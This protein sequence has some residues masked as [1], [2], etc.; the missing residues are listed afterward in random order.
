[1]QSPRTG[2]YDLKETGNN[3]QDI[4]AGEDRA[5]ARRNRTRTLHS[6]VSL[7]SH[8]EQE[9]TER[10]YGITYLLEMLLATRVQVGFPWNLL[11]SFGSIFCHGHECVKVHE[12]GNGS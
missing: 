11:C 2:C 9:G 4:L 1:M 8:T 10:V 3:F 12:K 5:C 7:L 6:C